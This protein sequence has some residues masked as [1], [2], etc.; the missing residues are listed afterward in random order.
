M[1]LTPRIVAQTRDRLGESPLWHQAEQA[2]YWTDLYGPIL[3]RLGRDGRIESWTIPGTSFIGSFVFASGGRV[4]LAI[5]TGL[6]LFEPG[7]GRITPFADPNAAREGVIYNDS[8][9]DRQ[10]RL[11]VGTLDLA[12]AEPRGMLYCVDAEGNA[13]LG[14]GGFTVCNGP[15]FSPD[16]G[17]LYFSDSVGRRLL[18]Y[19]LAPGTP[20]LRNRR[21]F[22]ALGPDDGIPDGLT[23][24]A[25]GGLWCAHYGAGRLTRFAP[26][27]TVLMV[28][29]L[30]CP[31]VT[32]MGF[33][34]PDMTTLYVTTG[35]SPG[36]TRAED[37]TG[38][39]GALL[40]FDT[41][42][43]GLPEPVFAVG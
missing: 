8:K 2:I 29:D 9:I 21:V 22:A 7:S 33:G 4:M 40:A 32:S 24:D 34:G 20:V 36:V 35:W 13:R 23:V 26:D 19:D 3:H 17:V 11:W 27:G 37:E 39:G 31:I 28:I 1:T 6:A 15:A 14:D 30:P 5:D 18:A 10:G 12:E 41:G 16:G 43:R 42:I 25:E 38:P